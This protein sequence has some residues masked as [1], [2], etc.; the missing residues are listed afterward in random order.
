METV[1]NFTCLGSKNHCRW[2][3]QWNYKRHLLFGRKAITNLY[4]I[5]KS[6]DITLLTKVHLIKAMVFPVIRYGCESWT[7]KKAEHWRIDAFEVSCWRRLL[8]VFPSLDC[9]KIKPVHPQGNQ[10]WIFI[11]RTDAE[12]EALTLWPPDVKNW[13]IGKDPDAGKDWRQEEEMIKDKMVGWH[14]WVDGH[15]FKRAPGVGYEQGSLACWGPCPRGCK[16]SDT[17]EWT[18]LSWM[19]YAL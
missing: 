4:S 8:R 9:K 2:W 7:P 12:A 1:R 3:L 14:H 10:S 18:E 5:L 16:E 15:E 19:R 11:G 17:T 13:F 6:K